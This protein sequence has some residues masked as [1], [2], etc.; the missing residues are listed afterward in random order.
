M[1]QLA[2]ILFQCKVVF[3]NNKHQ[4]NLGAFIKMCS[5]VLIPFAFET[6]MH[7]VRGRKNKCILSHDSL[8]ILTASGDKTNNRMIYNTG[9]GGGLVCK[10]GHEHDGT[11]IRTRI[12]KHGT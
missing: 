3:D 6:L 1:D 5:E 4:C 11:V 9:S 10:A 2:N 8:E 7:F 12:P